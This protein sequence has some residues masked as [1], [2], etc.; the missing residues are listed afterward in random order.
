MV[1]VFKIFFF[2]FLAGSVI[3]FLL[4]LKQKPK[5]W[6]IDLIK[7]FLGSLFIFSGVVKAI[8]PLGTAYKM[9]DYFDAFSQF[10]GWNF[11][12]LA[13]SSTFLA[14]FMIVLEIVL[15]I[16]LILGAYKKIVLP[17]SA[18]ML[19]FFTVLTGFT[20]GTGY[21]NSDYYPANARKEAKS[22]G[23][24]YQFWTEFDERQMKVT[25]CGCFGDFLKLKPKHSFFKD[26]ILMGVLVILFLGIS[27]IQ[28]WA[29]PWFL[30]M[31]IVGASLFLLLFCFSN[32]IWGLPM[33]DFRPYKPG[34]NIL[35]QRVAAEEPVVKYF[36][37]YKNKNTGEEKNFLV[38]ELTALDKEE[39]EYVD[40]IEDV[41]NPGVPAKIQN[42]Y[43]SDEDGVDVTDHV[44]ENPEYSFW[45]LSKDL[46]KSK[47]KAWAELNEISK[48]ADQEGLEMFVFTP[49]NFEDFRHEVQAAYPFYTADKTF[50]KTIVRANP[51][52]VILQNGNVID[53]F[54]HNHIPSI[55]KVKEIIGE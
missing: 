40:R 32:Y 35:E 37:V 7:N 2:S 3:T 10:T 44:L 29:E 21:M 25:D 46:K 28:P 30:N 26:L 48:L 6:P 23:Q 53:K 12:W 16:A 20:F 4:S 39:W 36:F 24:D 42:F 50:V 18:A 49:S 22:S 17:V 5:S 13:S 1:L 9:K 41:I 47:K 52:L 38:S 45:I 11:D 15:G 43:A 14:V 54:H 19:V 34:K 31:K 8:D 27:K 55:E 33:F 51:G